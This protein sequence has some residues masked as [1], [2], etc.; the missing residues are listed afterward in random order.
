MTTLFI[1]GVQGS[2]M[3]VTVL[4]LCALLINRLPKVTFCA[5]WALVT[6][7]LLVPFFAENPLGLW[8]LAS[9]LQ[10]RTPGSSGEALGIRNATNSA[11]GEPVGV[12][13]THD[14]EAPLST[15]SP[16]LSIAAEPTA[17]FSQ[18]TVLDPIAIDPTELD[19][20]SGPTTLLGLL[21]AFANTATTSLSW[22]DWI[23]IAGSVL[24]LLGFTSLYLRRWLRFKKSASVTCP[25]ATQWLRA[26][27]LLRPLTIRSCPAVNN[28]L[29]YGILRP[30]I[31]VPPTFDWSSP[32]ADLVLA[33]EFTN[34]RFDALW[35][36]IL[37]LA[38]CVHWFNPFVWVMY[39]MA[40]RD[41]ELSCD[42]RVTKGLEP[43]QRA[44]YAR[45]LLNTSKTASTPSTPT[46]PFASAFAKNS[47]EERVV[48]IVKY[49]P[50]S[51]SACIA[52]AVV[53]IVVPTALA[54]S[55]PTPSEPM[56]PTVAHPAAG[57]TTNGVFTGIAVEGR[58]ITSHEYTNDEWQALEVLYGFACP[59]R[60][61]PSDSSISG[62]PTIRAL[63]EA[64]AKE[65]RDLN[66]SDLLA[67]LGSD[68]WILRQAG[69]N[70]MAAFI[71]MALVPL[72]ADDWE[73]HTFAGARSVSANGI[74]GVLDYRYSF[75]LTPSTLEL[76]LVAG[77]P[78]QEPSLA[79]INVSAY[80]AYALSLHATFNNLL[81]A[82]DPTLLDDPNAVMEDLDANY[83]PRYLD[84]PYTGHT[85]DAQYTYR[86]C[87][88]GDDWQTSPLVGSVF[89]KEDSDPTGA[90][91]DGYEFGGSLDERAFVSG[92]GS[93]A[94]SSLPIDA[95][96]FAYEKFGFSRNPYTGQLLYQGE[97]V[98]LFVD[99]YTGEPYA[100]A[101]DHIRY[102]YTSPN[103]AL[104]LRTKYDYIGNANLPDSTAQMVLETPVRG[105]L[106][107]DEQEA[108]SVVEACYPSY[109][110]QYP[111]QT[112]TMLF[113]N[114]A[115]HLEPTFEAVAGFGI[116]P[117]WVNPDVA[118]ILEGTA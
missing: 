63:R 27:P 72:A 96:W 104:D 41:I 18:T 10:F 22:W 50:P 103:G 28:P 80:L 92:L 94:V 79:N 15:A 19:P 98:R 61:V 37:V 100:S 107:M 52:S 57:S 44:S 118:A 9:H 3:I 45:I 31:L 76:G 111:G 69:T 56:D 88:D 26:H 77:S 24:F 39:V 70:S 58:P 75:E 17:G 97:P 117:S 81:D 102:Y 12:T 89:A 74:E 93:D 108:R 16:S 6:A 110:S 8:S 2:V 1:M 32:Q 71:T 49:R 36:L 114:D 21:D 106:E 82:V 7:R 14:G 73:N 115:H 55:A 68:G 105:V 60:I 85:L 66:V 109:A 46:T 84:V 48:S 13:P 34:A 90:T 53:L 65:L 40:N 47:I 99:G 51:W 83:V 62:H 42:T 25:Q 95:Q 11:G 23:W 67:R 101:Y 78:V 30:V 59:G 35:K 4:V 29:T 33:H 91:A 113:G 54:T 86:A 116:A 20:N 5:L 43:R 87:T 64:I 112:A 38:V